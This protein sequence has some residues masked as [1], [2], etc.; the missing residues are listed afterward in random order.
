[1]IPKENNITSFLGANIS[2]QQ[3]LYST[4]DTNFSIADDNMTFS[5][6]NFT[7]DPIRNGS[8]HA[9]I[10]FNFQRPSFSDRINP[11]DVNFTALHARSPQ[12][13]SNTYMLPNYIPDENGTG[14]IY[15]K[16]YFYYAK[17][18]PVAPFH[19]TMQISYTENITSILRVSVYCTDPVD[20]NVTCA[21]M[22]INTAFVD[23][24]NAL[25]TWYRMTNH[26]SLNGEGRVHSLTAIPAS[27]NLSPSAN[28]SLDNNGSSVNIDARYPLGAPRRKDATVTINADPWL[29]YDPDF[30]L[31][32][33]NQAFRWKGEGMTGHVIDAN[34]S[35]DTNSKR[36]NW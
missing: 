12:A 16:R 9:T 25:D 18:A 23:E 5:R 24:S 30:I 27:I 15:A 36:L 4:A 10:L 33:R 34:A 29:M 14:T 2:F 7:N 22:G 17:V 11:I 21:N 8:A 20:N 13:I 26:S 35:R 28:I 6:T 1:M 19:Q 3:R 32:F 31:S